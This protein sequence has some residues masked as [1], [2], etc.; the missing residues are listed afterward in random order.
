M[1]EA[2][3]KRV[4]NNWVQVS[5]TK[6]VKRYHTPLIKELIPKLAQA[7]E[8]LDLEAKNSY[9]AFLGQVEIL[10]RT[11]INP[12]IL[13]EDITSLGNLYK[14]LPNLMCW[15]HL[16]QLQVKMVTASQKFFPPIL[17]KYH[18]CFRIY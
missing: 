5:A 8:R 2:Q 14:L 17:A 13:E 6:T 12:E 18:L 9:H 7:R 3:S 11:N 4:P 15:L 1:K 10:T 16:P